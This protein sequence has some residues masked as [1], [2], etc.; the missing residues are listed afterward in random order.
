MGKK[1]KNTVVTSFTTM[2]KQEYIYKGKSNKTEFPDFID[3]CKK[4]QDELK[5]IL[6]GKLVEAG[7][8]DVVQGDG[9][10]YAKGNIPIL[11]TAH[12]D[13]VHKSPIKNFY[14]YV[15]EK[16][17]HVISSPQGIGG[18]DRCGIYII[19]ETIKEYKP[20]VLF[21]EDEESGGIGSTKFC[22]TDLIYELAELNY[23][24]ELDRMN[25]KDAVFYDCANVEF[26]EFICEQTG[27]H[28]EWGTFSDISLLAPMAG[29]AAVN[30]SCGYYHAHTLC[31]EVVVEE[32]L[33]T[34]EVVKH[35]LTTESKQ[36]EYIE[37]V[38]THKNDV[39]F[40]EDELLF[41][42]NA[43][44][45]TNY[46]LYVAYLD[47]HGKDQYTN[48]Y[49]ST[50]DRTWLNFFRENPDVCWNDILDYYIS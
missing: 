47:S 17:N 34:L 29:I 18:D 25:S 46:I 23:M 22:K 15:D 30:L 36:Y 9:Y 32:M 33:H 28:E 4:T 20:S 19:L 38:Y 31:E 8:T 43:N 11:L 10:I 24:I 48:A 44:V 42:D 3:I 37:W 14:E 13:T 1:K 49:G 2:T 5:A 7:Y 27:Y 26:A 6:P 21:C 39:I 12:M 35:L 41:E 45:S 40:D 50:W 16:G